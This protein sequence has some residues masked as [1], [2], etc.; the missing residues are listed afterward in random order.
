MFELRYPS[1]ICFEVSILSINGGPEIS[2]Q[3]IP[4]LQRLEKQ[5]KKG[6]KNL[7]ALLYTCPGLQKGLLAPALHVCG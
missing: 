7:A 3:Q 6:S 2:H 1:L 5:E 4:G